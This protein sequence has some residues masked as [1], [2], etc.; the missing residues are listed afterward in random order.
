MEGDQEDSDHVTEQPQLAPLDVK[1]Q[2]PQTL[3]LISKAEP[4]DLT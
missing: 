1:E 2:R 3:Y 4:G